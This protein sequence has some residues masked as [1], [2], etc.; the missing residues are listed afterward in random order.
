[1]RSMAFRDQIRIGLTYSQLLR[2]PLFVLSRVQSSRRKFGS[3]K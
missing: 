3:T 1:L 2:L